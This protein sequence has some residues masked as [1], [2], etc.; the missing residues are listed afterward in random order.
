MP[1]PRHTTSFR[2]R[3]ARSQRGAV[4]IFAL[5]SLVILLIGAVAMTR[6]MNAG[7]TNAGNYAFK[8]DLGNQAERAVAR[9]IADVQTGAL[10]VP[11]NRLVAVQASNYSPTMLPNNAQGL[12]LALLTDAAFAAV[13]SS[14]NDITVPDQGIVVR[15][16][17]DQLCAP[18]AP[19]VPLLPPA[20]DSCTLASPPQ[21][22]GG[23][24]G[25]SEVPPDPQ[26]VLRVSIRVN[27]PRGTQS[28]FQAPLPL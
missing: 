11:A 18:V 12:P 14:A 15:Y 13:G 7:L 27:G 4:L 24:E 22:P 3:D 10:S 21:P 23:S 2:S 28:F 20:P 25:K 5:I 6:S 19:G 17:I 26:V 1:Q 8:R 9:A 16:V